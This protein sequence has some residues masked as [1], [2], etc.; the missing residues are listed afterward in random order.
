ME[1]AFIDGAE[2][3][4]GWGHEADAAGVR[5]KRAIEE[6]EVTADRWS[7]I[8]KRDLISRFCQK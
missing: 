7:L 6:R 3:W 1:L 8:Q 5:R 2:G 4:W